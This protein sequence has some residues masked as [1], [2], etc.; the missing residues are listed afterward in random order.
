MTLVG[1]KKMVVY[2]D[3]SDDKI[4]VLDKGIDR[5][6][7]IGQTMDY[8]HFDGYHLVHRAGDAWLPRVDVQEPLKVEAAHFLE[9]VRTGLTP[10]SGP[11]HARDVVAVLEATQRSLKSGQTVHVLPHIRQVA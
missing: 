1:A 3:M 11:D 9:C 4:M 10:L 8:D 7:K 6:P 2:D 5:V